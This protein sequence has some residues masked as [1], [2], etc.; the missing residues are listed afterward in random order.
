MLPCLCQYLDRNIFRNQFAIDQGTKERILCLGSSWKSYFNLFKPN[1]YK[2]FEKLNLLFQ[3]HWD[4]KCLVSVTKVYRT[5]CRCL[6]NIVLFCPVH[7]DFWWKIILFFVFAYI[8]H[9]LFLHIVNLNFLFSVTEGFFD[10]WVRA[11]SDKAALCGIKF[12]WNYYHIKKVLQLCTHTGARDGR[13]TSYAV[14]LL[15]HE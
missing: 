14:P 3:A 13:H 1:L 15:F 2:K 12:H 9:F 6:V 4:D 10:C 5:P 8:H 7:T 11:L